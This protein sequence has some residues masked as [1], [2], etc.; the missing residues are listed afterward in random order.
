MPPLF[1]G[2]VREAKLRVVLAQRDFERTDVKV[3]PPHLA[4]GAGR[5][6][7]SRHPLNFFFGPTIFLV[8]TSGV[9]KAPS[10]ALKVRRAP[11]GV[12]RRLV[13]NLLLGGFGY[14]V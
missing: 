8:A 2:A 11:A 5:K 4:D 14:E 10:R 9:V 1:G 13:P 6:N 7:F 12:R 3:L